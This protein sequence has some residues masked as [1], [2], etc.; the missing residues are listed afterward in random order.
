MASH[1]K[2]TDLI[3]HIFFCLINLQV[4]CKILSTFRNLYIYNAGIK[5]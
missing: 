1:L 4:Q 2:G 5:P 3:Q